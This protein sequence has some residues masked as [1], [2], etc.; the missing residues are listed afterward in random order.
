MLASA[1]PA[2]QKFTQMITTKKHRFAGALLFCITNIA[3][4]I[5]MIH[6]EKNSIEKID[7]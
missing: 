4:I 3:V 6:T 2:D 7:E 1:S 5:D